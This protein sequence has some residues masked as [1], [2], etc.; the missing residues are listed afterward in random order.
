MQ[1]TGT[2]RTT[3]QRVTSVDVVR[4]VAMVLMALDHVRD[5][6]SNVRFQP[7]NLTRTNADPDPGKQKEGRRAEVGDP[8]CRE[9]TSPGYPSCC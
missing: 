5:W 1:D 6:V 4:G 9:D 3:S 7:E 2:T 8:S